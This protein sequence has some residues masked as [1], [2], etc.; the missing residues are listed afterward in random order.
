MKLRPKSRAAPVRSCTRWE[1]GVSCNISVIRS[2][3]SLLRRDARSCCS[4]GTR[5]HIPRGK[6]RPQRHPPQRGGSWHALPAIQCRI[7]H[8]RRGCPLGA[9]RRSQ[10]RP[11]RWIAPPHLLHPRRVVCPLHPIS[12]WRAH[13]PIRLGGF[14]HENYSLSPPA[15]KGGVNQ[16]TT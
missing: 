5:W 10:P 15:D 16:C 1:G 2:A 11:P 3:T 9:M 4:L 8:L 12:G 6:L 7:G 13:T 14:L